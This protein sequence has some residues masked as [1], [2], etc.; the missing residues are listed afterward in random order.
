MVSLSNGEGNGW[1]SDLSKPLK[2]GVTKEARLRICRS[3]YFDVIQPV[4][5][6]MSAVPG[7]DRYH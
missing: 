1:F 6:L 4:S 2:A 5:L 7:L 3:D